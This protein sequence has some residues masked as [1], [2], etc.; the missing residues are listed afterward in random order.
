MRTRLA[1]L[2]LAP[3][4]M[5]LAFACGCG[6]SAGQTFGRIREAARVVTSATLQTVLCQKAEKSYNFDGGHFTVPRNGCVPQQLDTGNLQLTL[7]GSGHFKGRR[8]GFRFEGDFT[9]TVTIEYEVCINGGY[10]YLVPASSPDIGVPIL[11]NSSFAASMLPGSVQA[12]IRQKFDETLKVPKTF[13]FSMNKCVV[14]GYVPA[15]A[16]PTY[17]DGK[18]DDHRIEMGGDT[19]PDPKMPPNWSCPAS[20]LNVTAHLVAPEKDVWAQQAPTAPTAPTPAT[21][22][23]P[24]SWNSKVATAVRGI[25]A[26]ETG[27]AVATSVQRITHPTEKEPWLA[28][29]KIENSAEGSIVVS[30]DV[31]WHGGVVGMGYTTTVT[32]EIGKSGHVRAAVTHD[33]SYQGASG[34]AVLDVYFRDRVYPALRLQ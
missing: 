20:G 1:A 29:V 12:T 14:S 18:D 8:L 15:G 16:V 30:I 32:W 27:I 21:P 33:A 9:E 22:A 23:E 6:A 26:G 11:S 25:L 28:G 7:D 13:I 17:C 5:Y 31:G 10:V 3:M 19:V 24:P 34:A 2:A 4:A